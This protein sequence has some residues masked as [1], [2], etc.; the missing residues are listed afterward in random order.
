[1]NTINF[2]AQ[3]LSGLNYLHSKDI[4]HRDIK[5]ANILR[6]VYAH[7]KIGDFGSAKCLQAICSSQGVD[8]IG[9]P[10]FQAPEIVRDSQKFDQKSDIWSVGITGKM[11]LYLFK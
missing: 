11:V 9:T 2:T 10:H 4:V 5:S 6:D 7:L 8:I 1:M 3:I